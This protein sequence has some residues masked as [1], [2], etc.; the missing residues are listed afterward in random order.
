MRKTEA[1]VDL[2]LLSV[3]LLYL[4]AFFSL[5]EKRRRKRS[6]TS[7]L[8]V[9]IY[10]LIRDFEG[11][12]FSQQNANEKLMFFLPFLFLDKGRAGNFDPTRTQVHSYRARD[13]YSTNSNLNECALT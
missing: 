8:R 13:T 7:S 6:V 1:I 9:A 3:D 2:F 11:S 4:L 10:P 12:L 5:I